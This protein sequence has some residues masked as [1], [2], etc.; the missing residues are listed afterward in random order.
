MIAVTEAETCADCA[1]DGDDKTRVPF[2]G[3]D[4]S[5]VYDGEEPNGKQQD[6]D[7]VLENSDTCCA[8]NLDLCEDAV[9]LL[10]IAGTEQ[11]ERKMQQFVFH[12]S[13]FFL[14]SLPALRSASEM[15]HCNWPLVERNSS[16]AH[17]SM[18]LIVSESMRNIKLFVVVSFLAML[19]VIQCTRIHHRLGGIVATEHYE[20]VADHGSLLVVVQLDY[21]L[22]AQFL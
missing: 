9:L 5:D 19:L 10:V 3:C 4:M 7:D 8:I 6:S 20:Q 12:F 22:V 13:F 2:L 18:A 15:I 21:F 11:V 1:A 17:A 16:A 14:G